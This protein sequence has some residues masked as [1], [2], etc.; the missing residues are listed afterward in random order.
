MC[1]TGCFIA[2]HVKV[3]PICCRDSL[4]LVALYLDLVQEELRGD[5]PPLMQPGL[6]VGLENSPPE[7][8]LVRR[9]EVGALAEVQ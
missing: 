6:T 9:L 5:D 4:M 7:E 3:L 1:G 8:R 2:H